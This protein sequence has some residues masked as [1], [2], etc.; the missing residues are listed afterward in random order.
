M[1]PLYAG[2]SSLARSFDTC[3]IGSPFSRHCQPLWNS[4]P[5]LLHLSL[6]FFWMPEPQTR[7]FTRPAGIYNMFCVVFFSSAAFPFSP[8]LI[9]T[10]YLH[11]SRTDS[12]LEAALASRLQQL[13][14]SASVDLFHRHKK[15]VRIRKSCVSWPRIYQ[16]VCVCVCVGQDEI[17]K[18]MEGLAAEV[19]ICCKSISAETGC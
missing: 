8:R 1:I 7:S 17:W 16:C 10:C 19:H 9:K 2:T 3:P 15:P 14:Y 5:S 13:G 12:D 18:L 4:T 6:C 11:L